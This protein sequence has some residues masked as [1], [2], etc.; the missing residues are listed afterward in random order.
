MHLMRKHGRISMMATM[1]VASFKTSSGSFDLG[2]KHWNP[3]PAD[4]GEICAGACMWIIPACHDLSICEV[5]S[6]QKSP[7]SC[8]DLRG[9]HEV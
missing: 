1:G 5:T 8:A 9:A 6:H 7:A 2:D 4:L 3:M